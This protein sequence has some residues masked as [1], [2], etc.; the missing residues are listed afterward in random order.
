MTPVL[1][2]HEIA[3][4]WALQLLEEEGHA[5]LF[6]VKEGG[7]NLSQIHP[8]GTHTLRFVVRNTLP[9]ESAHGY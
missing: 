7:F 6:E 9:A 5:V 2:I 3:M 1:V 8:S 4:P